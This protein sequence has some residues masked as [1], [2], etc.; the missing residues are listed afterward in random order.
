M[1][2]TLKSGV[3]KR[4]DRATACFVSVT[5]PAEQAVVKRFGVARAP[6]PICLGGCSQRRD[7]GL[8]L[9]EA[10]RKPIWTARL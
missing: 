3:A 6:L 8:V 4:A 10:C 5:D 2:Q 9:A 7:H 1:A